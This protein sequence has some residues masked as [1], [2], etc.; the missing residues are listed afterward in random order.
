MTTSGDTVAVQAASFFNFFGMFSSAGKSSSADLEPIEVPE[1]T[2]M[3]ERFYGLAE[4]QSDLIEQQPLTAAV[5]AFAGFFFGFTSLFTL[6]PFTFVRAALMTAL[7]AAIVCQVWN[8]GGFQGLKTFVSRAIA[9][10]KGQLAATS[11]V[12]D[13]SPRKHASKKSSRDE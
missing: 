10:A 7:G 12:S 1:R 2:T 6:N 11:D 3:M 9:E 13:S 4:L 8:E 5:Y